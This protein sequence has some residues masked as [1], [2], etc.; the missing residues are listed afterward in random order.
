MQAASIANAAAAI[1][2]ANATSAGLLMLDMPDVREDKA[3]L[4]EVVR[5]FLADS[6]VVA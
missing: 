6:A 5:V 4:R 1:D 2:P 3:L